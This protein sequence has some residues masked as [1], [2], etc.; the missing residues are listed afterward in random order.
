[1][2]KQKSYHCLV[3]G[4]EMPDQPVTVLRHQLFHAERRASRSIGPSL[5][6]LPPRTS[7]SSHD[8]DGAAAHL[9]RPR[10]SRPRN[11]GSVQRTTLS[12]AKKVSVQIVSPTEGFAAADDVA[13]SPRD[14]TA[15][16]CLI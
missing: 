15:L 4:T 12:F 14:H 3:C 5:T 7:T 11:S 16:D 1:M 2:H 6:R 10:A 9:R 13:R 8:Y